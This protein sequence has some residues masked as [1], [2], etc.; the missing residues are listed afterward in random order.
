MLV[1]SD[2]SHP[3]CMDY[4]LIIETIKKESISVSQK[5]YEFI[6]RKFNKFIFGNISYQ[7]LKFILM[8]LILYKKRHGWASIYVIVFKKDKN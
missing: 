8:P 2:V 7:I 1:A 6:F 5:Y 4:D 3:N